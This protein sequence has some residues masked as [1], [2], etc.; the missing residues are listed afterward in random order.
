MQTKNN[1]TNKK[2]YLIMLGIIAV[3]LVFDLVS[4]ALFSDIEWTEIIPFLINFQTNNGNAGVAFGL[5]S[6]KRW[7]LVILAVAILAV[8]VFVDLKLKSKSKVYLIGT[9]FVVG[10]AIGNLVDRIWLGYV[11]DFVNFTFWPS[12]P[13]FNFADCFLVVGCILLCVYLVFFYEKEKKQNEN[14]NK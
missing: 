7:F 6:G 5:F 3:V 10:G 14:K 8:I 12:Y 1:M 11:R 13:T 9:S 4:K 2:K